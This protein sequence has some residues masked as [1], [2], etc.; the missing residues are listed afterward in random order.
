M[1]RIQFPEQS[2]QVEWLG[3]QRQASCLQPRQVQRVVHQ[4]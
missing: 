4:S 2:V 1:Q 3:C